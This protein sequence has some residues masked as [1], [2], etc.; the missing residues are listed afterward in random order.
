[1]NET[2]T[3]DYYVDYRKVKFPLFKII[4]VCNII[5]FFT[6]RV[7][8]WRH[9]WQVVAHLFMYPTTQMRELFL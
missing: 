4:F 2:E 9:K 8:V 7:Q 5:T 6:Q 1:M 3:F